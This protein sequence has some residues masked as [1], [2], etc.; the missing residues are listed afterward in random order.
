[1]KVVEPFLISSSLKT[2]TLPDALRF[3]NTFNITYWNGFCE[4]QH[5]SLL[6]SWKEFLCQAPRF[7]ILV[8]VIIPVS[9]SHMN[10]IGQ[11]YMASQLSKRCV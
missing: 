4:R 2:A 9:A 10:L 1:M 6:I 7:L 3:S 5:F 11:S 8:H